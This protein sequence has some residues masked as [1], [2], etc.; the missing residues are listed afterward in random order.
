MKKIF[1]LL[2]STTLLCVSCK[3]SQTQ[4]EEA[5]VNNTNTTNTATFPLRFETVPSNGFNVN[6]ACYNNYSWY[7]V[8]Y[9]DITNNSG[10]DWMDSL[11][12]VVKEKLPITIVDAYS[13]TFKPY[14]MTLNNYS[15]TSGNGLIVNDTMNITVN[16]IVTTTNNCGNP[17]F[18]F[19][20]RYRVV[21]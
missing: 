16:C 6:G 10:T 21:P 4:P 3:K 19:K 9:S 15:V 7:Y 14:M 18:T 13:I 11:N 2:L 8:C 1:V 12:S 17:N 20:G 5:K